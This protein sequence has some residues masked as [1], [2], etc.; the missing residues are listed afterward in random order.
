MRT[1]LVLVSV[2]GLL[3]MPACG[4]SGVGRECSGG[5]VSDDHCVSTQPAVYWTAA[6]A[7]AAA[8]AFDYSPMAPGRLTNVRCQIVARSTASEARAICRGLFASPGQSVR[9]VVVAFN[10]SGIGAINPDCSVHWQTS[11][12][13]SGRNRTAT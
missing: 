7:R 5:V 3:A 8:L 11:P 12:Y 6:K 1:V 10:L 2:A 4:S 13:C 9:P